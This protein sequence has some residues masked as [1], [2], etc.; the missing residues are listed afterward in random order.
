MGVWVF[1][2]K[3]ERIYDLLSIPQSRGKITL[4]DRTS[5]IPIKMRGSQSGTWSQRGTKVNGSR[6]ADN[7]LLKRTQGSKS[8]QN[9]C[10]VQPPENIGNLL[11]SSSRVFEYKIQLLLS[12]VLPAFQNLSYKL[13]RMS[14]VLPIYQNH[15]K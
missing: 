1:K 10:Q 13:Q 6:Y 9:I 7:P 11:S 12:G 8:R 5:T 4:T 2:E 14:G 3:S 15:H